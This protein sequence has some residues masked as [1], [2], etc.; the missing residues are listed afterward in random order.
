M[1]FW[2]LEGTS[3]L[4]HPFFQFWR[5]CNA[6]RLGNSGAKRY[7]YPESLYKKISRIREQLPALHHIIL[8]DGDDD[9]ASGVVSYQ[10]IMAEAATTFEVQPT[11]PDTPSGALPHDTSGSSTGRPK[12]ALH[13]HA[14][15]ASQRRTAQEI[16]GLRD[17]DSHLVHRPSGAGCTSYGIIGPWSLGV[18]QIH[19]GGGDDAQKWLDILE[20]EKV[21]VWYSAP[22]ALRMLM[23]EEEAIFASARLPD[24]RAI[25]SVGEPLNPEVISGPAARSGAIFTTRGSRRNRC[26]Y[27]C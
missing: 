19:Y 2:Y 6:D 22:T 27:D 14:S 4:W 16:L 1:P 8:V 7:D 12:G 21:T 18:T 11:L 3:H 17:D 23:R 13:C 9:Q 25:F 20:R 24:L 15:L 26:H 10:G 5:G